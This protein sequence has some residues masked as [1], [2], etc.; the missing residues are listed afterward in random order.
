MDS[1]YLRKGKA[2]KAN[3]DASAT[4]DTTDDGREGSFAHEGTDTSTNEGH[5]CTCTFWLI[6]NRGGGLHTCQQMRMWVFLKKRNLCLMMVLT[7]VEYP[8]SSDSE[9]QLVAAES[10]SE[11]EAPILA[12][13]LA[14][15]AT[16][17][18]QIHR[19]LNSLLGVLR[20]HGSHLPKDAR[21]LFSTPRTVTCEERG[22]GKY[23]YFGLET[24]ILQHITQSPNFRGDIEVILNVDG[25]YF[26][27]GPHWHQFKIQNHSWL[28]YFVQQKSPT[29]SRTWLRKS[30]LSTKVS[31]IKTA[32]TR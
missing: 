24:G 32:C 18:K 30:R 12:E 14:H 2:Q 29:Q 15:W 8:D 21:T 27:F 7:L 1:N 13:V 6:S 10:D 22:N 23:V 19:N 9:P 4:A 31:F 3:I 17:T 26:N 11:E 16:E 5:F 20:K 28:H 25:V